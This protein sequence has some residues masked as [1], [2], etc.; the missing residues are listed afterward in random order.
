MSAA[1]ILLVDDERDILEL[2][3]G[4]LREAGYSVQPAANGDIALVL[5]EQGVPF[6]LLVTDIVM[7]GLLDGYALARRARELRPSM[8]VIYSTGFSHVAAIRSTGAPLGET[9]QKPWKPSELLRLVDKIMRI[10]A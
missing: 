6:L 10:E 1:Q 5:I 3:A 4:A 7:P 2:A 9:L 8:R